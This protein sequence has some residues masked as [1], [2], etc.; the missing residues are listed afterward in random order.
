MF[1]FWHI[2][3]LDAQC[4][5]HSVDNKINKLITFS[6]TLRGTAIYFENLFRNF[7]LI[8]SKHSM[9]FFIWNLFITIVAI[10]SRCCRC[11][12]YCSSCKTVTFNVCYA[13]FFYLAHKLKMFFLH[14]VSNIY[15]HGIQVHRELFRNRRICWYFDS[16]RYTHTLTFRWI[17]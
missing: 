11:Y 9:H 5:F 10:A 16:A 2:A 12:Y 15:I 8:F 1:D 14:F 13:I 4:A 7:L 3:L 17:D 6:N